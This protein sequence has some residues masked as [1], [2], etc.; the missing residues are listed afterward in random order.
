MKTVKGDLVELAK[1]GTFDVIVHGCNCMC[2]MG[3]GIAKMIK[4]EFPEAYDADLET[5]KG[6]KNK[7][8]TCSIGIHN[9]ANKSVYIVNAYT[10]FDYKGKGVLVDYLAFESCL[11][12]IK[13]KFQGLSI[14]MPKI[15]AGLARGDWEILY[16]IIE[17]EFSGEDVT[18]VE[19]DKV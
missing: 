5:L 16:K 10:Q 4:T 8:G 7:L 12:Y 15:G 6:D 1:A 19:F 13:Q 11:K 17:K 18:I 3:A 14:G 9:L 2:T